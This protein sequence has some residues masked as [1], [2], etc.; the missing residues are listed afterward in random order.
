MSSPVWSVEFKNNFKFPMLGLGTY[1][2]KSEDL[3]NIVPEAIDVGYR[4]F[5]T[6]YHYQVCMN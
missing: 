5:D 1:Q 3:S 4:H 6:A 2:C